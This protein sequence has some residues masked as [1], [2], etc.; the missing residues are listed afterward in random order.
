MRRSLLSFCLSLIAM[1]LPALGQSYQT[2]FDQVT[3]DPGKG[4]AT[5][6]GDLEVEG[7]TG[8]VNMKVPLGPGIGARGARFT[9]SVYMRSSA[10]GWSKTEYVNPNDPALGTP[11]FLVSQNLYGHSDFALIFYRESAT[12]TTYYASGGRSSFSPG[13]IEWMTPAPRNAKKLT[14]IVRP[15]GQISSVGEVVPA[16]ANDPSAVLTAF[17]RGTGQGWSLGSLPFYTSQGRVPFIQTGSNGEL[18]LGLVKAGVAPELSIPDPSVPSKTWT[19]PTCILVVQG[20]T[21]FEYALAGGMG[22]GVHISLPRVL[23][24]GDGKDKQWLASG[25]YV[26]SRIMNRFGEA[27]VFDYGVNYLDI[28]SQG[29][30]PNGLDYTARWIRNGQPTGVAISMRFTGQSALDA[31]QPGVGGLQ[32][33]KCYTVQIDY[34]G[35]D[36]PPSY[37][38]SFFTADAVTEANT[39]LSTIPT[40]WLAAQYVPEWGLIPLACFPTKVTDRNTQKSISFSYTSASFEDMLTLDAWPLLS[41]V[42]YP[43]GKT[44][45]LTWDKY[46]FLP[47]VPSDGWTGSALDPNRRNNGRAWGVTGVYESDPLA[48][49]SFRTTTH[50]RVVPLLNSN[51]I[52]WASTKFYDVVS[53]VPFQTIPDQTPIST[54]SYFV[55]PP[56]D[57]SACMQTF[58]HLKHQVRETRLYPKGNW[59]ADVDIP[60]AQSV[61]SVITV[62]DRWDT[63]RIGNP[64][65]AFAIVGAD[66]FSVYPT[67]TRTWDRETGVVQISEMTDWDSTSFG[68]KTDHHTSST[69]TP[70]LTVDYLSLAQQGKAYTAYPAT[71]GVERQTDKTFDTN[72]SQWFIARVKTEVT[73]TKQDNTGFKASGV[74]LPDKQPTVSKTFH[75]SLNRVESVGVKGSDGQTL[76]TAFQYQ[77]TSGLSGVQLL[78]AYLNST[79]LGLSGQ[80]GVS[81]YGYDANGYLS[82][83]SQK[84]NASTTLTVGQT[85]DALG[86]PL[87]QTDPNGKTQT[88]EWDASGRLIHITPSDGDQDTS[89]DYDSDSRGMT[90]TRGAQVS[91]YRYNAFGELVL[92]R[93]QGPNGAWSHRMFGY[94]A[95]GRKTGETVWQLGEGTN[96]ESEWVKPHLTQSVTTTTTTPGYTICRLWGSVNPD[97]GDREC[98]EWETIPGSTTTTTNGA[99]YKGTAITYDG[100]GRVIRHVDPNRIEVKTDYLGRTKKVTVGP[101]TTHPQVTQYTSDAAGRLVQ[102]TDATAHRTEYRYDGGDRIKEVKQLGDGSQVQTRSW[103]YNRLGWLTSLTQPESGTTTY[104]KFDVSGK[105]WTTT[106]TGKGSDG[107]TTTRVVNLTSDWMGR[108]LSLTAGDGSVSQS[109]VYDTAP[110]AGK[111]KLASATANGVLRSMEYQGGNGRLSKLTRTIDS[112]TFGQSF[113]YDTY[114]NLTSRTYPDGKMQTIT[115]NPATGLPTNSGF[116]TAADILTYDPTTWNLSKLEAFI[117]TAKAT[118]DFTYDDDQ[119]RLHTMAHTITNQL[120]KTWTYGYDDVGPLLTDGEDSYT[121]D[122]LNRLVTAAVVDPLGTQG[123]FQNFTYDAFGNRISATTSTATNWTPPNSVPSPL[124]KS[125]TLRLGLDKVTANIAFAPGSAALLK[126]Q[127]PASLS[128]GAPTGASYDAQGNLTQVFPRAGASTEAIA[129][130]YDALARVTSMSSGLNSARKNETYLYDDEG[131]RIRV[132]DGTKYRYNI[133]NEAR[134]VIAQYESESSNMAVRV[135]H[136]TGTNSCLSRYLGNFATGDTL[137]VTVWFKTRE[138]VNAAMFIGNSSGPN[139]Y[140]NVEWAEIHG[141]GAW[142]QMRLTHTMTHADNMVVGLYA[143]TDWMPGSGAATDADAVLYDHFLAV[144]TQKGVVLDEGFDSGFASWD[145]AGQPDDLV[146]S[147]LPVWKKDIVYI[148]TKEVAEVSSDGK[149]YTTLCDHLGS[150]RYIWSGGSDAVIKQKFLPFGEQLTDPTSMGKFAKGF[151]NHEQTDPSGLI[152]MQARFYLPMYGRF[153]S[154]DPAYD[155][156]FEETQSWNIYSYCQNGPTMNTDPTGMFID[157]SSNPALHLAAAV[158]RWLWPKSSNSGNHGNASGNVSSSGRSWISPHPDGGELKGQLVDDGKGNY[159]GQCV[160]YVKRSCPGIPSTREWIKGEQVMGNEDKV[161]EGT[162]VATF[163]GEN[164]TYKGHAAI[165]EKADKNEGLTVSEQWVTGGDH[166]VSSRTLPWAGRGKNP[167]PQNRGDAYHVIRTKEKPKPEPAPIKVVTPNKRKKEN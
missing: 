159:S 60:S 14:S 134:Q 51:G 18:V 38:L 49:P 70:S 115:P 141:T 155:Q 28:Q 85:Q 61:A 144:S 26:L 73:T 166:P 125:S 133:Y 88:F 54:V 113:T 126:N 27:I 59:S 149:T 30:L 13:T 108:P 156:H 116:G 167:K 29:V 153:G 86:R 77:G 120:S 165:L 3:Y 35:V 22:D 20:D 161:P 72:L 40:F 98:L 92:E 96:H 57:G 157:P 164:N 75:A 130:T 90:V 124:S 4:P 103:A 48:Y 74:T 102:V 50:T 69:A 110:G 145:S 140:D 101:Q 119:A 31:P 99:A 114:G 93:R 147:D 132:W 12:S 106:Y 81:A 67:R 55:E 33:T 121:Y 118:T 9:P 10:I 91:E 62:S 163:T 79:G 111:G 78:N 7:S 95:F 1:G 84:P 131:L 148:G 97:T 117:G 105:P 39:N 162:A 143:D 150:P 42:T 128:N 151:T 66:L 36:S 158:V 76:T 82:S 68:W 6:H 24:F 109:F 137:T 138:G 160:S 34:S 65:G 152:Y 53:Q 89:I 122:A 94:D 15:D 32:L 37:A 21:A 23:N 136:K 127:I 45:Q 17:G 87:T 139:A 58:A 71:L 104:S 112:Q 52:G 142:Q 25:H 43:S 2:R 83:I 46:P 146:T 80:F 8:A 154:P 44:T 135:W 19:F 107:K 129:M 11:P 5:L 41:Q 64:S 63:R 123:L 16:T 100:R 47:N 56:L